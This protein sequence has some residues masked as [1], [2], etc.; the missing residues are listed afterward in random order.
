MPCVEIMD[1]R[2]LYCSEIR[3]IIR[4]ENG[5]VACVNTEM[6]NGIGGLFIR[7]D[8]LN[9]FLKDKDYEMLY[10]VCGEKTEK[11]ESGTQRVSII[12][13]S[14]AYRYNTDEQVTEIQKMR[15]IE[16]ANPEQT[17]NDSD[18]INY[19]ITKYKEGKGLLQKEALEPLNIS[20]FISD[21]ILDPDE[22]DDTYMSSGQE[23]E[24]QDPNE[25]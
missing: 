17:V 5:N 11:F 4:E 21:E 25:A 15:V 12:D 24:Y 7:R 8:I 13:L 2:K 6:N 10:Y 19:L 22:D 9:K 3:G 1:N 23:D 18:R 16:R 20:K 14:A